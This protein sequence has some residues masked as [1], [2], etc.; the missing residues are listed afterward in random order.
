MTF[1]AK[2]FRNGKKFDFDGKCMQAM[3]FAVNGDS[4]TVKAKNSKTK[5]ISEITYNLEDAVKLAEPDSV[6]M[7]YTGKTGD[8]YEFVDMN[9]WDVFC[10]DRNIISAYIELVPTGTDCDVYFYN[11]EAIEVIPPKTVFA[12]VIEIRGNKAVIETGAEIEVSH[13]VQEG[14]S[15]MI[16]TWFGTSHY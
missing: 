12:D 1:K 2:D 15:I 11:G 7:N 14:D 3:E 13:H 4:I 16:D 10:F 9:S 5:E 6:T 8:Q